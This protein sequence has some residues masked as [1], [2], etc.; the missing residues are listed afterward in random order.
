M[1][2][3][4]AALWR[5]KLLTLL[6]ALLAVGVGY[7]VAMQGGPT[8][9][10][11]ATT[12]LLPPGPARAVAPNAVDYTA[13]NPLFYLG[14]LGQARDILIGAMTSKDVEE[15]ISDKYPGMT[16][17]VGADVLNSAP[18]VILNATGPDEEASKA[19]VADLVQQL[20]SV[21]AS[22]QEGVGVDAAAQI[23]SY[24]LTADADPEI[25]H[26]AQLRS[27]IV[28]VGAA[29][30]ALAFLIGAID[31]LVRSPAIDGLVRS[32]K[33]RRL[34][35]RQAKARREPAVAAQTPETLEWPAAMGPQPAPHPHHATEGIDDG[36]YG[37]A[38]EAEDGAGH[39]VALEWF[40]KAGV[41]GR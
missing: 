18:V 38:D 24:P 8:Y 39:I 14:N 21:L 10:Y 36:G 22:V 7:G 41:A 32:R 25:S 9:S 17:S 16:Y 27:A 11:S 6:A 28:A 31:G 5:R 20:P 30:V 26:K 2:S 19:L 1:G 29:A 15:E 33:T 3:L 13:G 4:M 35:P 37:E 12:L 34:G 40:T 23:T